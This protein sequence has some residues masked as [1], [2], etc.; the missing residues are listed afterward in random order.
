MTS[1]R[2]QHLTYKGNV[3]V[4]RH[5]WL[6]LT[7]AYSVRIVRDVVA[8]RP[9]EV[10]VTDPFSGTGTTALAAAEH[11]GTGQ[12]LDVNPFLIW[13]GNTKLRHYGDPT[14]TA[15]EAALADVLS[16]A[17]GVMRDPDLWQPEIFKIERWWSYSALTALKALRAAI[18]TVAAG[19]TR[20]LL[21]IALCRTLIASSNAAFNH[22][23][24][25]FKAPAP[26]TPSMLY[27][28]EESAIVLDRYRREAEE[29]IASAALDLPGGGVVLPGDSRTMRSPDLRPCD[30]LLTSPPYVNR[31]SYIRELRPYMYWTRFLGNAQEAG[32]LD[33]KA[34]GGTWGVA[35]SR[36]NTWSTDEET[37]VE[38]DV[39]DVCA[40]I[41]R[42]GGRNGPLLAAYVRKYVDDM[43]SHFQSAYKNIRSG[44]GAT[45]IIGNSTFYR[46]V[47]PA[48]RWYATMLREA[49][50]VNVSVTTIRKRN[51][52]K[53]LFEFDVSAVRP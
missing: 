14:I 2:N 39:S 52:N 35:T 32:E 38:K 15:T 43:W 4:G 3:G 1:S 27:R 26:E 34:I 17:R 20:D 49:G 50:F 22:Q 33:W 30:L 46:H 24:M 45:Y 28:E 47:V 42:D 18:D 19:P 16:T 40:A 13:L 7:P 9:R 25:S 11:G 36:L 12:A 53:N 41:A 44:G 21:D 51:S 8:A 5:G 6:R 29:I 10:V 37:P 31:M 48:E 23:S